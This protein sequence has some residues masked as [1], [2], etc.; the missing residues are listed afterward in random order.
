MKVKYTLA[1]GTIKTYTYSNNRYYNYKSKLMTPEEGIAYWSNIT[2][3][4]IMYNSDYN[5]F[6][7]D[8]GEVF[9][10]S[11]TRGKLKLNHDIHGYVGFKGTTVHKLVMQTFGRYEDGKDVDH[12]NGIRNDN[13]LCNL[14]MLTHKE[15]VAKRKI[16]SNK[17]IYCIELDKTF[18]SAVEASKELGISPV[19]LCMCL[20][21]KLKTTGGYHWR[22]V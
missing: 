1:D 13:R 20:K 11:K 22:Y 3:D 6:V 12:I 4:T 7:S 8:K 5:V 18:K 14:Q 17:A 10:R 2:G 9:S 16:S 15:N 21:G 19:S